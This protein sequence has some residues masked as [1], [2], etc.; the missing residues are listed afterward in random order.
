MC[1]CRVNI[2]LH[3]PTT[4]RKTISVSGIPPLSGRCV[5]QPPGAAAHRS[6]WFS[7]VQGRLGPSLAPPLH[8]SQPPGVACVR[9]GGCCRSRRARRSAASPRSLS[10]AGFASLS[11]LRSPG[12]WPGRSRVALRSELTPAPR[13]SLSVPSRSHLRVPL[14]RSLT[15]L[16]STHRIAT[17]YSRATRA[18]T[19][20]RTLPNSTAFSG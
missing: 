10:L 6:G 3:P 9:A 1:R 2:H 7:R 8:F 20:I 18:R 4:P 16:G 12:L 14:R 17:A 11:R 13:V 5:R 15:D 19:H